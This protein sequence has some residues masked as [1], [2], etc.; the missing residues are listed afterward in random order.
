[1]PKPPKPV[2]RPR[3][4]RQI[5]HYLDRYATTEAHLR[6]LFRRRIQRAAAHH[7]S[8]P[9]EGEAW[10]EEEIRRVVRLG[11]VNDAQFATDRARTLVRRGNGPR[12]VRSKLVAKGVATEL[13]EA[14]LAAVAEELGDP[15]RIAAFRFARRRKLGPFTA[16]GPPED[17]DV[18]QRQLGKLAR[19][20]FGYDVARAIIES[21]TIEG[22]EEW[23]GGDA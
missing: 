11:I 13:V 23:A 7:G 8:D 6:R 16:G 3:L 19:A 9:A 2:T 12:Q 1:M 5:D 18:Q 4:R 10:L 15:T 17:R 21:P 22:L 14:A 20:G